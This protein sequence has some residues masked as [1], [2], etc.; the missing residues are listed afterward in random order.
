MRY[1]ICKNWLL[2]TF[3]PYLC[4][5]LIGMAPHTHGHEHASA[6]L[7]ALAYSSS[8]SG[9]HRMSPVDDDDADHCS[10][11]QVQANIAACGALAFPLLVFAPPQTTGIVA[12]AELIPRAIAIQPSSRAPPRQYRFS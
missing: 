8:S 2:L 12:Y 1:R 7:S 9:Q 4:F 11:C 6:S 10:L 3:F 5:A